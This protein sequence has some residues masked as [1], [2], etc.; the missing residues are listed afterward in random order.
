MRGR[1]WFGIVGGLLLAAST[2]HA[3]RSMVVLL[4]AT[5]SMQQIRSDGDTRYQAAVKQARTRVYTAASVETE[6]LV[7]VAVLQFNSATGTISL[8]GGTATNPT[9]VTPY[10]A[11]LI[12]ASSS[13]SIYGTPLADALCDTIDA[14]R[15]ISL[16]TTDRLI[17]AY[18]DG[19]ENA[20]DPARC[21]GPFSTTGNPFDLGSWQHNVWTRAI[22]G[23]KHAVQI[24]TVLYTDVA[25]IRAGNAAGTPPP[26]VGAPARARSSFLGYIS[27][28]QFFT[29]LT[30]ATGGAFTVVRDDAPLPVFADIDGDGDVDRNDAIALARRFGKPTRGGGDLDASGAIGWKDYAILLG[31]LGAGSGT[32]APDPYVRAQP[33]SCTGDSAQVV[34]DGK[35]IE[36]GGITISAN[37]KCH[38]IIRNSLIVSGGAAIR[39]RGGARLTVDSSIIVGEGAWISGTGSTTLS[40]ANSV[41]HGA[42]QTAGKLKLTDR[43]G[44]VFE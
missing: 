3:D 36:D 18:T 17:E 40:A 2:A 13:V 44:N 21:G 14:A 38:V 23:T 32:P 20:S 24:S 15:L 16:T 19:A 25:T 33:I 8:S 10:E 27:D 22:D 6:G 1:N 5:G 39:V 43:G 7:N 42:E 37:E 35:V 31:H 11:D 41:F 12:I 4:D 29:E 9:F 26:E 28:E 30:A 34:L